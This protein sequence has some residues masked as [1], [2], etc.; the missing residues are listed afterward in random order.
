MTLFA[1]NL[2]FN[3]DVEDVMKLLWKY[4]RHSIRMLEIAIPNLKGR[5]KGYTFITLS[6]VRE[7]LVDPADQCKFSSGV[8]QVK[9][10]ELYFQELRNY[11]ADTAREKAHL[12]RLD[13][14][15]QQ[16]SPCWYYC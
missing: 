2:D 8:I 1:G 16:I 3:A 4:F 14:L 5:T 7:A 12:A 15:S 13:A 6:W 10:R 11:V 9:S